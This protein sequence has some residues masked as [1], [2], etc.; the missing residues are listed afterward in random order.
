MYDIGKYEGPLKA[1]YTG[2]SLLLSAIAVP[3]Y[4]IATIFSVSPIIVVALFVNSF[5]ISLISLVVFWFSLEIYNS[6]RMA[7]VLSLI[8]SVCS[9]IRPYNTSLFPQPLQTL[10]IFTSAFFIY[11][12]IRQGRVHNVMT[13]K[14]NEA[15]AGRIR[16]WIWTSFIPAVIAQWLEGSRRTVGEPWRRINFVCSY[17]DFAS[18]NIEKYVQKE[19]SGVLTFC[20]YYICNMV[21]LWYNRQL[22]RIGGLGTEIFHNYFAIRCVSFGNFISAS[23]K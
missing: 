12:S 6:I 1:F 5:I 18:N 3:F 11:I 23:K 4:D 13:N 19:Q 17:C 14:G 10:C 7:F 20:L 22:A 21:I 8:F 15:V 9:F 16:L 2:R